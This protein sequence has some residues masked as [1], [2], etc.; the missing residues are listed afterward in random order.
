MAPWDGLHRRSLG[1]QPLGNTPGK[2]HT[3]RSAG[4]MPSG[5]SRLPSFSTCWS[6]PK[7]FNLGPAH[8]GFG[9]RLQHSW[10]ALSSK[11][12]PAVTLRSVRIRT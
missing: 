7:N 10:K 1:A 6:P 2:L 5:E 9:E 8:G 12:S 4:K 3:E 11:R